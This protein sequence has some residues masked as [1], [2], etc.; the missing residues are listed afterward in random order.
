MISRDEVHYPFIIFSYD[1]CIPPSFVCVVNNEIVYNR[2]PVRTKCG[3]GAWW[4]SWS[5]DLSNHSGDFPGIDLVTFAQTFVL[6]HY[7]GENEHLERQL[8][9]ESFWHFL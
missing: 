6:V 5:K 8:P 4:P 7:Y 2:L 1:T 9:L 3:P